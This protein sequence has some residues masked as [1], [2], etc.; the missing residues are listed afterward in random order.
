MPGATSTQ[1]AGFLP[2]WPVPP[3]QAAVAATD[4]HN[5]AVSQRLLI[6]FLPARRRYFRLLLSTSGLTQAGSFSP[7]RPASRL[8]AQISAM[9]LRVCT[10]ALA[11]C[12]AITTLGSFRSG[13]SG[14]GGSGSV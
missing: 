5:D 6:T 12:G 7:R 1:A 4:R 3:S 2:P 14:R 13:L 9:A 10:V 11:M 8:L